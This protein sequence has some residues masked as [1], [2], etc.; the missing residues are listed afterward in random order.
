MFQFEANE[1]VILEQQK[2]LEAALSTNPKTEKV[3]RGIIRK[4]IKEARQ[5]VV[6]NIKFKNGDPRGTAQAV[7]S[8]VYKKVFGANLNIYNSRKAHGQ[9]NYEPTRHPSKRGGN[10]RTRSPRTSQIMSYAPLD[11][12][13]I[14]RFVNSGTEPRS[15]KF[16]RNGNRKE[17][18]W[19]HN[20]NTGNRGAIS[21][22][23]FFRPAGDR[24]LGQMRDTIT[25][26]IEQELTAMLNK[27]K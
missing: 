3:L 6:K 16:T 10:R 9:N 4:Y 21:A 13:F 11:R 23:N 19:N 8:T 20:P 1:S 22:R 17:D 14:M 26:V 5:D 2:A 25:T 12:G 27:A 15:I 18:K 24:A 7:R